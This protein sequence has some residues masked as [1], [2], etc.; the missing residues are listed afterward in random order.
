MKTDAARRLARMLFFLS[1]C[2]LGPARAH[3]STAAEFDAD[4]PVKFTGMVQKVAWTNPHIYTYIEVTAPGTPT[5]VYRVEGGSPNTLF[6]QGW[7]MESLKVGE[8]VTV[9]GQAAKSPQS[10]NI[11]QASIT[12]ADGRKIFTGIGPAQA[13]GE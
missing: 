6:R 8:V 7:R 12:T 3:H 1:L 5:K 13:G 4:K 10:P 9:T 11:G 2:S